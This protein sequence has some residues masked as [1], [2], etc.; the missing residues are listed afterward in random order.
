MT[1]CPPFPAPAGGRGGGLP[2][3]PGE[4]AV[5]L[6]GLHPAER[7]LRVVLGEQLRQPRARDPQPG[8]P[9]EQGHVDAGGAAGGGEQPAVLHPAAQG[10]DRAEVLQRLG[11]GPVARRPPAAQQVRGGQQQRPVAGGPDQL[12]AGRRGADVAGQRRVLRR[13]QGGRSPTG[14]DDRPRVGD[15]GEGR[16][17]GEPP[18][19]VGGQLLDPFGDDDG[20]VRRAGRVPQHGQRADQVQRGHAGVHGEREE[21]LLPGHGGPLP[22]LDGVSAGPG[23]RSAGSVRR[24]RRGRGVVRRHG[25]RT[26]R[27][28]RRSP[29][30]PSRGCAAR[31]GR[32]RTARAPR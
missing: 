15:V 26:R 2:Q 12:G 22:G 31:T 24:P 11:P 19:R 21:L 28:R 14:H 25:P 27:R 20:A 3:R 1:R 23:R 4:R 6:A 32:G 18:R 8:P 7:R 29:A 30:A 9:G 17:R 10:V 5:R 13:G 16:G